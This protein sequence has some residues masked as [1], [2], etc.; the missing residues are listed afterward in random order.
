MLE[1]RQEVCQSFAD[2][3]DAQVLTLVEQLASGHRIIH[4]HLQCG[5]LTLHPVTNA[6][7]KQA[8][9]CAQAPWIIWKHFPT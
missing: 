4:R 2:L 3:D 6:V 9:A 5:Q 1:V 8:H 7:Q